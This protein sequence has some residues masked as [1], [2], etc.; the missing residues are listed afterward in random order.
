MLLL[1]GSREQLSD[2][3]SPGVETWPFVPPSPAVGLGTYVCAFVSRRRFSA[4][5]VAQLLPLLW[6]P[7]LSVLS[8]LWKWVALGANQRSCSAV[9]ADSEQFSMVLS[10]A[11]R[12]VIPYKLFH[13]WITWTA[14]SKTSPL[15]A[16]TSSFS[17]STDTSPFHTQI[18]TRLGAGRL[19]KV[20]LGLIL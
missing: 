12:T 1:P 6:Q 3:G 15:P 19:E 2:C 17:P 9:R 5:V 10:P 7:L 4:A 13:S 18:L 16:S 8:S 14:A 11:T 20:R